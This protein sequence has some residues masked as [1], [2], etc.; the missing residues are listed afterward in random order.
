MPLLARVNKGV[1]V[2]CPTPGTFLCSRIAPAQRNEHFPSLLLGEFGDFDLG[3][4]DGGGAEP[5]F[6]GHVR[7]SVSGAKCT[8]VCI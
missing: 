5:V 4:S 2:D 1:M 8:P 7:T 6:L 3:Q